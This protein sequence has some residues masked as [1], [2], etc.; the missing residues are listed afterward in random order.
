MYK[1]QS[2]LEERF[3][4]ELPIALNQGR[5]TD[6]SLPRIYEPLEFISSPAGR[7]SGLNTPRSHT[8]FDVH[9]IV[10][11]AW[12]SL[13]RVLVYFRGQPVGTIAALDNSEENLN[14]DQVFVRD[15]VPSALA[16]LM[17]G[18]PEIVKNFILKTLRLQS[19][20][21]KIDR[22][23]FGEGVMPVSFKVLHDPVRNSETLIADFGESAIGRVAPVDS[24]F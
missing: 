18:E 10:G 9:P 22:F 19:W 6:I 3:L 15:F 12:D 11:E 20:E 16:F 24:G 4:N 8:G 1:R 14:Y 17:N 5:A 13:R 23:Q 21:K 2:S 7:R